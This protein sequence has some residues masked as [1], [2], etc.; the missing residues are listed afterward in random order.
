MQ[1]SLTA[2]DIAD[3]I[4]AFATAFGVYVAWLGLGLWRRQHTWGI[5]Y[6]AAKA[7]LASAQTLKAA[8]LTGH[9]TYETW[10]RTLGPAGVPA[11]K[12]AAAKIGMP[13]VDNEL[14]AAAREVH[15]RTREFETAAGHITLK[16][17]AVKSTE[18]LLELGRYAWIALDLAATDESVARVLAPDDAGAAEMTRS[19][20]PSKLRDVLKPND[21]A[22]FKAPEKVQA[23]MDQVE[24][25]LRPFIVWEG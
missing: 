9:A 10:Y 21:E 11:I 16:G 4:T 19:E 18:R 8:I 2:S 1:C 6:E 7:L 13:I 14:A 12:A 3:L 23:A 24:E 5:R 17:D 22:W 25:A 15:E 20:L